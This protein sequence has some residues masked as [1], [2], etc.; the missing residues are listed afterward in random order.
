M[1]RKVRPHGTT[2]PKQVIEHVVME[3]REGNLS[4][5][6][7]FTSMPPWRQGTHKSSTDWTQRMAWDKSTIIN[8]HPSGNTMAYDA[9]ASMVKARYAALLETEQYRFIGDDT[10][11]QT[12]RGQEKMT[13]EKAR[14]LHVAIES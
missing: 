13:S 3:L 11:W 9:F 1:L 12:K 10:E 2:T 7:T 5:A 14:T 4:Q 8:G 6:F